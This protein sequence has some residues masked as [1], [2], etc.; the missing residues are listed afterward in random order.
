[1]DKVTN[2][3]TSRA[4]SKAAH[5]QIIITVLISGVSLL[6]AG[7]NAAFSAVAGGSSVIVGGLAGMLMARRPNGGTPNAILFSL[8]KAE[9]IRVLVIAMLLLAA[10]RYYRGLVPLSLIGGL[11]GSALASGAGLRAVNNEN[12]D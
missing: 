5:W 4:F 10:F 6:V 2:T 3:K 12:D 7:M 8:L 9:V 11:A 1:M